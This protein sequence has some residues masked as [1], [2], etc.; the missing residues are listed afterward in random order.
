MEVDVGPSG[1]SP[2][3]GSMPADIQVLVCQPAWSLALRPTIAE[4]AGLCIHQG[5]CG[6]AGTESQVVARTA[7]R[8][9]IAVRLEIAGSL[10]EE[11]QLHT[12]GS[13][14]LT[15][16]VCNNVAVRITP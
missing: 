3:P 2:A 1:R 8:M 12:Q 7:S 4:Q 6:D 10:E 14:K 15:E 13:G 5:R 16:T 11:A 9:S